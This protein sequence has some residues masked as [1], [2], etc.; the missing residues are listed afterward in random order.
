MSF[1][2]GSPATDDA[3]SESRARSREFDEARIEA[4]KARALDAAWEGR[5]E[6]GWDALS[7]QRVAARAEIGRATVYRHWPNR[8]DLVRDTFRARALTITVARTGDLRHDLLA[9]LQAFRHHMVER[10]LGRVLI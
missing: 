3:T 10:D 5:L 2:P 7:Q 8:V 1:M 9:T 4:S 6:E